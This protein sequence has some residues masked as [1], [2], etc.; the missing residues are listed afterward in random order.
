[1]RSRWDSPRLFSSA[2][3]TAFQDCVSRQPRTPTDG[4]ADVA[5]YLRAYATRFLLPARPDTPVTSLSCTDAVY[6]HKA[7]Q[8]KVEAWQVVLATGLFQTPFT[9]PVSAQLDP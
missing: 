6:V 2:A 1:M 3:R 8:E 5:E 4:N 7:A 9:P